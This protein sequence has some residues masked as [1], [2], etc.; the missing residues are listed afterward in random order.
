MRFFRPLKCVICFVVTVLFLSHC[1][2]TAQIKKGSAKAFSRGESLL[3]KRDY[4]AAEEAF[5]ESIRIDSNHTVAYLRLGGLAHRNRNWSAAEQYLKK[6]FQRESKKYQSVPLTLA[7][8]AWQLQKHDEVLTYLNIFEETPIK[9]SKLITKAKKLRRDA[10]FM[11]ADPPT[12][13]IEIVMLGPSINTS[14]PEYLPSLPAMENLMVF[15]RRV[16][17]QEDFF[18]TRFQ[19]E[20][21]LPA[22]PIEKLNTPENEGAHC[23]SADGKLLIFTAC[24]RRDGLG[25]CDLYFSVLR[26]DGWSMPANLGSPINTKHWEG[27]PSLSASAR[28]LYFSSTR[29]GGMGNRDLWMAQRT[30]K[31]WSPPVNLSTINTNDN[32]ESPYIHY[33]GGSLYFMS[34]GHPGYGGSDLFLSRLENNVWQPPIN[35]GA[36]I[37]TPSDEGAVHIDLAGGHGYFARTDHT[38]AHLDINILQFPLPPQIRPHP[39]TYAN[40][41]VLDHATDGPL[42]GIVEVF[43]LQN[44]KTFIKAQCGAD[45]QLLVCLNSGKDYAFSVR[46]EKYAFY[47]ANID[48]SGENFSLEPTQIVARLQP[49][50]K[51]VQAEESPPIVL[52]NVFFEFAKP[53]L[54]P[55]SEHELTQ[56]HKMLVDQPQISIDIFGHTDNIGSPEDNLKLSEARAKTI[57]QHLVDRGI[58]ADRLSYQGFGES[59]PVASNDSEEGRQQNRRTEFKIR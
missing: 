26:E 23:L 55:S 45:G 6:V 30:A 25:G 16:H 32:E 42:Q 13:D 46:K 29:P 58:A 59:Q 54:L 28:T 47:S 22:V 50:Q 20:K 4:Q 57:Y 40:I 37:N 39:A 38:S 21:W 43:D 24:T 14:A 5:K 12:H 1:K 56:L 8:V 44:N 35:L 41:L 33:D 31:G 51:D 48:L 53:A 18:V 3:Q 27:Q 52:E 15:T 11:L 19:N 49:L 36:P 34:D 10:Q 17:G 7:E 2:V 9:N